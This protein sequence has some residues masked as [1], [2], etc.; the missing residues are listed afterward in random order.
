M[1]YQTKERPKP[2]RANSKSSSV[3]SNFKGLRGPSHHL[4]LIDYNTMFSLGLV[5][6]PVGSSPWQTSHDSGISR[7]SDALTKSR[8]HPQSFMNYNT[9]EAS[10]DFCA[11][12]LFMSVILSWGQEI[13]TIPIP[14]SSS[15]NLWVSSDDVFGCWP[16]LLL[17]PSSQQLM[18]D[19]K[20]LQILEHQKEGSI[21][22]W[23]KLSPGNQR[24]SPSNLSACTF[25]MCDLGQIIQHL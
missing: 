1:K 8:L 13:Y 15:R 25:Q 7:I 2:M 12:C 19:L 9:L 4:S 23:R 16:C 14:S 17:R 6:L 20:M 24:Y 21:D 3:I 5:P 11:I 10:K 22:K 18:S